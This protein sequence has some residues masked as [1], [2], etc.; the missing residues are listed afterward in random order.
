MSAGNIAVL[1]GLKLAVT[2]DTLVASEVGAGTVKIMF[3]ATKNS[4]RIC[5]LDW[6]SQN[7]YVEVSDPGFI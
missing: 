2:G 3:E 6:L 7:I 1:S 4:L 5:S